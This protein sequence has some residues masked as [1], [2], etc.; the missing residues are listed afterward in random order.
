MAE[1][2]IVVGLV[3]DPLFHKSNLNA[4]A[5]KEN[6]P[7]LVL[8]LK[9]EAL[10][11]F[12]WTSFVASLKQEQQGKLSKSIESVAI[13]LGSS[14]LV[15]CD[16]SLSWSEQQCGHSDTRPLSSYHSRVLQF[17]ATYPTARKD[18]MVS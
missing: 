11:E 10:F 5:L 8:S 12:Q 1:I 9:I 2:R 17:V 7:A 13:F 18:T 16:D 15:S 6:H 3:Q 14:R 4:E